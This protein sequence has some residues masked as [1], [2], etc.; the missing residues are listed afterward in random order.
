MENEYNI[1]YFITKKNIINQKEYETILDIKTIKKIKCQIIKELEIKDNK[2]IKFIWRRENILSNSLK[3]IN[4]DLLHIN[5]EINKLTENNFLIIYNRI[6]ETLLKKTE[7]S[8][9][10][11]INYIVDSLLEKSLIQINFNSLYIC[12]LKK[13]M[14]EQTIKN[15][16]KQYLNK[17]ITKLQHI[18]INIL[19]IDD[20]EFKDYKF[21][22]FLKENKKSNK[23]YTYLGNIYSLFYLYDIIDNNNISNIFNKYINIINDLVE[24]TPVDENLLEKTINIFIGLLEYGYL[25]LKKQMRNED[26][27]KLN[28]KIENIL[29]KKISLRIKFNLKNMYEDLNSN[30]KLIKTYIY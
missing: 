29:K 3:K 22:L 28:I 2:V 26:K 17:I 19:N 12:F 16:L 10:T 5:L 15:I 1:D 13:L 25:K 9:N 21:L 18:L 30:S 6:Y 24:W 4:K 7:I 27:I 11:K 8:N 14:K 23:Q 20:S